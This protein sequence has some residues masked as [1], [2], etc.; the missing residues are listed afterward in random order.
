MNDLQVRMWKAA[1]GVMLDDPL[2]IDSV[3]IT[4]S[5]LA[6]DRN[7][8]TRLSNYWALPIGVVTIVDTKGRQ[9][10]LTRSDVLREAVGHV[11]VLEK[12]IRSELR[13]RNVARRKAS[14]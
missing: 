11:R 14:R 13:T 12:S 9:R 6:G 5:T 10:R 8:V 1:A 4:I 7:G 2:R 3:V